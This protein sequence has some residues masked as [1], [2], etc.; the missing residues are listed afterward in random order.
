[1]NKEVYSCNLKKPIWD[2][3]LFKRMNSKYCVVSSMYEGY[4]IYREGDARG[5]FKS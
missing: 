1:M 5:N 2:C 4:G 3:K